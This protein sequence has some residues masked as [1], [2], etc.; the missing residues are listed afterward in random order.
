MWRSMF[1]MSLMSRTSSPAA[2]TTVPESELAPI[3]PG[4]WRAWAAAYPAPEPA[5]AGI[6][7]KLAKA[8]KS[9]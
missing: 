2:T 9:A 7:V 4:A 3:V 5:P 1:A 8:E 6:K